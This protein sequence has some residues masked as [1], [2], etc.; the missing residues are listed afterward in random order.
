MTDFTAELRHRCRNPKC[1]LK[2][3]DT[4]SNP[5]DAFCARGCHGSFYL[6]RCRICEDPIEQGGRRLGQVGDSAYGNRARNRL[7]CRRNHRSTQ[8]FLVASTG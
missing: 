5:R 7:G 8:R 6:R 1:R 3:P 2:L 4:V